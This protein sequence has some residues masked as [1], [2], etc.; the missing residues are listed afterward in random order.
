V[1]LGIG[2]GEAPTPGGKFFWI[3]A[4]LVEIWSDGE[5]TLSCSKPE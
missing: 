4:R 5:T 1:T 2:E 3:A